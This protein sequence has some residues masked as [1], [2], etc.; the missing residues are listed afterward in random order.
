MSAGELHDSVKRASLLTNTV[1]RVSAFA[2]RRKLH[3]D[4][5]VPTSE[6]DDSSSVAKPIRPSKAN[7]PAAKVTKTLHIRSVDVASVDRDA[8][9]EGD[10]N[11]FAP[12][13]DAKAVSFIGTR[14]IETFEDKSCRVRLSKGQV[15]A[16]VR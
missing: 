6:S 13:V 4:S 3:H 2:K 1:S 12:L 7:T 16:Q 8:D 10:E 9:S 15:C 11:S 5:T 14:E